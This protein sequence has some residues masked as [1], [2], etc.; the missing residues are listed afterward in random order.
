MSFRLGVLS[1]AHVHAP[2]YAH[3]AQQLEGVEFVGLWDDDLARGAA[4]RERWGG[5]QFESAD[6]L[7]AACDGV[8]VCSENLKHGALVSLAL[9]AG[10]PVL[11]EKPLFA[12]GAERELLLGA[13]ART[14]GWVMTAF[15]CPYSPAFQLALS[16]VRDG[17]IGR[18]VAAVTT[19]RGQC[20]FGW[21][22]VPELSGG[23]AMIDHTVH[24]ADLLHRI[25]E[26]EPE[27]VQAQTGS[28]TY[29]QEWDDTAML[30]LGYSGGRFA[31]LDSSWSRPKGF[32]TWGDVTLRLVGT[33]ATLEVDLFS[34][35]LDVYG[36][37]GT[38]HRLVGTGSNLDLLMVREFVTAAQ[39]GRAPLTSFE[40]GVR[41]S[42][43][44]LR[45]YASLTVVA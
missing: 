38:T 19:N 36:Q 27:T 4:F 34:A 3:C 33:E 28:N 25:F 10:R 35:G 22:T 31:S 17:A 39:E 18:L 6:A 8:V 5:E 26:E 37:A 15:P 45:A 13:V 2:S 23:G 24:V 29:G 21:F 43:V 32:K 20:P 11:C 7:V 40:D 9:D 44:A 42:D 30:T 12:S 1:A 16:R 14:G 41:A